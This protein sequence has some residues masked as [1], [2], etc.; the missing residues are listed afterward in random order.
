MRR[1]SVISV[2]Q[3][4]ELKEAFNEFDKDRSGFINTKVGSRTVL[5]RTKTTIMTMTIR[6]LV[7]QCA[8][9]E[10]TQQKLKSLS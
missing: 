10:E 3:K 9:W 2:E 5:T 7:G 4:Q 6:S 1:T 8:R